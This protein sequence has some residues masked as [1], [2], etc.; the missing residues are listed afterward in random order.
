MTLRVGLGVRRARKAGRL[1]QQELRRGAH[2][3]REEKAA[4]T[5][6]V[7]GTREVHGFARA[8]AL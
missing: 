5:V 7:A 1:V 6:K 2:L 3:S 8:R 4:C